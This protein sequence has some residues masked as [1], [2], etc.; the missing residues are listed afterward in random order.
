MNYRAQC[1]LVQRGTWA[2]SF[3]IFHI[4]IFRMSGRFLYWRKTREVF[5]CFWLTFSFY[6][7]SRRCLLVVLSLLAGLSRILI[8]I[9]IFYNDTR[10]KQIKFARISGT[11]L[12][13]PTNFASCTRCTRLFASSDNEMREI[14]A[15]T[16]G[17]VVWRDCCESSAHSASGSK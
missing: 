3:H 13:N 4:S 12:D 6:S 17:A 15:L 5:P 2:E 8:A 1:T 7:F 14:S 16:F 10:A 9:L 11:S